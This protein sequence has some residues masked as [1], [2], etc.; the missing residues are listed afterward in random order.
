METTPNASNKDPLLTIVISESGS[1]AIAV[2]TPQLRQSSAALTKTAVESWAKAAG[3]RIPLDADAVA[4][5]LTIQPNKYPDEGIVIARAIQPR[6]ARAASLEWKGDPTL[7]VFPGDVFGLLLPPEE[8]AM[9]STV[10]G[11]VIEPIQ[12]PDEAEIK[13]GADSG[14]NFDENTHEITATRYGIAR[15]DQGVLSITPLLSVSGDGLQILGTVHPKDFFGDPTTIGH[16]RNALRLAKVKVDL[17][18][19]ALKEALTQARKSGTPQENILMAEGRSP[20]DGADGYFQPAF[21]GLS[22]GAV[23]QDGRIN[24][25]ERGAAESVQEGQVLGRIVSPCRGKPGVN[26]YGEELMAR[27]GQPFKLSIGEGVRAAEDG[28]TYLAT[29]AGVVVYSQAKL[30]VTDLYIVDKDLD[31]SVGNLRIDKG[32]VQVS[33]NVLEGFSVAAPG[34]IFIGQVV[35]GAN[36]SAGGDVVVRGGLAMGKKGLIKASGSIFAKF[37]LHAT[38]VSDGDVDIGVITDCDITAEGK[39]TCLRDKGAIVGGIIRSSK[40]VEAK[41]IGSE[42]GVA[43]HIVLGMQVKQREELLAERKSLKEQIVKISNALG[44]GSPKDI[45]K[46]TPESKRQAVAELI[47]ALIRLSEKLDEVNR[48][49]QED[50]LLARKALQATLKAQKAIYPGVSITIGGLTSHVKE[51]IKSAKIF[52]DQQAGRIAIDQGS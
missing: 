27:D 35:E 9:G 14:I 46:R 2:P 33:G 26:V 8:G 18:I 38:L 13:L 6:P 45:L 16:L 32:S 43:T 49:I 37:A 44:S 30:S 31:Y 42:L 28:Q 20:V 34:S 22:S 36:I 24:F 39:V 41:E 3:V 25:M 48:K 51:T 23:L 47:R 52:Y 7:P 15:L 40:G 21:K 19:D 50:Q 5:I 4:Q 17:K 1:E 10:D 12:I 29:A 11:K